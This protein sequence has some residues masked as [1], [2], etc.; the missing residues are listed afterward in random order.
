VLYTVSKNIVET[1]L[2]EFRKVQWLQLTGE[3]GNSIS[4]GVKFCQDFKNQ[5]SFKIG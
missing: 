4:F 5:K 3:A 1:R 2:F